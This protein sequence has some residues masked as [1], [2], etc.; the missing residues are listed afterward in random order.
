[1]GSATSKKL[2]DTYLLKLKL[3]RIRRDEET[4][5]MFKAISSVI[6]TLQSSLSFLFS[7]GEVAMNLADS[8]KLSADAKRFVEGGT[9][10]LGTCALANHLANAGFSM[11]NGFLVGSYCG[12][13]WG[14]FT[15]VFSLLG[16]WYLGELLPKMTA[17]KEPE[18]FLNKHAEKLLVA[19]DLLAPIVERIIKEEPK[20]E[21]AEN[22][23]ELVSAARMADEDWSILHLPLY[24]D[25]KKEIMRESKVPNTH[26]M[27]TKVASI[28]TIESVMSSINVRESDYWREYEVVCSRTLRTLGYFNTTTIIRWMMDHKNNNK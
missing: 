23:K 2:A 5:K 13:Q 18:E 21:I 26:S 12:W 16:L 4:K 9:R 22:E 20:C 14:I 19:K 10:S 15:T 28:R 17:A 8:N 11:L 3:S 6:L 24:R 1:M 7:G 27:T 25:A